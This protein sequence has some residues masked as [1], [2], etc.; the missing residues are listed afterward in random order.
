VVRRANQII[1]PTTATLAPITVENASGARKELSRGFFA[2][3]MDAF[4]PAADITV[5]FNGSSG[6]LSCRLTGSTLAT[7]R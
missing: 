2:F 7:L 3:P 1:Q 4:S 5:V 6:E